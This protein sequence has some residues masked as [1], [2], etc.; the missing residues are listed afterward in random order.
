MLMK[1]IDPNFLFNLRQLN[2]L[3]DTISG[4]VGWMLESILSPRGPLLSG[5]N[6]QLIVCIVVVLICLRTE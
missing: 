3:E 1:N 2:E 6:C 4:R 5:I